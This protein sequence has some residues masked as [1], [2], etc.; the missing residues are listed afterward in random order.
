MANDTS[1]P[2]LTVDGLDVRRSGRLIL[3]QV[4]FSVAAGECVALVGPNGAGKSTLMLALMGLLPIE[5]GRITLDRRDIR[6]ISDRRVL[7]RRIA[8]VPQQYEG[9]TGFTVYDMVAAGRYA[10]QNPFGLHS[11]QDRAI[12]GQAL[13]ACGLTDLRHRIVSTLSGGERQKVWLAAAIA[14]Q[15]DL[16]FL[17]E[18]TTALDPR[19]QIELLRLLRAQHAAGKTLIIICHDLNLALVLGARVLALAQGRLCFDEP[20]QAFLDPQHLRRVF[21]TEFD[22]FRGPAHPVRVWPRMEST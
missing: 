18:P 11:A 7:A 13:V 12:I 20:V 4:S 6:H 3:Q 22:L 16:L 2:V 14:Q 9:F 19:H 17:D 15:S 1:I 21:D 10:H 5:R 8:H